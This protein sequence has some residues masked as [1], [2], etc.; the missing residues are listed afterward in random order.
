L[1]M[2]PEKIIREESQGHFCQDG[3]GEGRLV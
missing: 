3:V 2:I 1:D